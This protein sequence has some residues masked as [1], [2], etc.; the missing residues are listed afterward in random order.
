VTLIASIYDDQGSLLYKYIFERKQNGFIPYIYDNLGT[1]EKMKSDYHVRKLI[2]EMIYYETCFDIASRN[3][4]PDIAP[5]IL[6]RIDDVYQFFKNQ[7]P[8]IR[9]HEE[10]E[11]NDNGTIGAVREVIKQLRQNR[12]KKDYAH[13][14]S[15][16]AL[17]LAIADKRSHKKSPLEP[18]IRDY[19]DK[20]K[21]VIPKRIALKMKY[22]I[23]DL[24]S[25]NTISPTD[26]C[27]EI[28]YRRIK[29]IIQY[30]D[31]RREAKK[32]IDEDFIKF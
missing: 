23:D 9:E 25:C 15:N 32:E 1:I 13:A 26:L 17:T 14:E 19:F 27:V 30:I 12:E 2:M 21:A 4:F 11:I 3:P 6:L 29:K 20:H 22:D 10:V 18:V 5:S 31:E 7:Y 16:K 28:L 24:F 8:F